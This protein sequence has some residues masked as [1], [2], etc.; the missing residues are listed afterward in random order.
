VN[1][2]LDWCLNDVACAG[3]GDWQWQDWRKFVSDS[4][5]HNSELWVCHLVSCTTRSWDVT[6]RNY[7]SLSFVET[8]IF[9]TQTVRAKLKN[10]QPGQ[11][12]KAVCLSVLHWVN[13]W[14]CWTELFGTSIGLSWRFRVTGGHWEC[15]SNKQN[16]LMKHRVLSAKRRHIDS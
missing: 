7:V 3:C 11:T 4:F 1:R 13:K 6:Q 16:A 2:L 10:Q 15:Q 8:F 9:F 14:T 12:W 5:V